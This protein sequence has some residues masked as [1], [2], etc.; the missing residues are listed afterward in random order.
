[1]YRLSQEWKSGESYIKR[2]ISPRFFLLILFFSREVQNLEEV[3]VYNFRYSSWIRWLWFL[4]LISFLLL[5]QYLYLTDNKLSSYFFLILVFLSALKLYQVLKYRIVLDVEKQRI[6][7]GKRIIPLNISNIHTYTDVLGF[8]KLS[9]EFEKEI[10]VLNS[11]LEDFDFFKDLLIKIWEENK[12]EK[13]K[14]L[15]EN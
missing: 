2:G 6:I 14:N 15:G 1:M 9:I 7:V 8:Q 10:L 12:F 13:P 4:I 5:F 3:K 11:T